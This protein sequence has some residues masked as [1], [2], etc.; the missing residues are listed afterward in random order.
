MKA[1]DTIEF[2]YDS[3]VLR[4][5]DFTVRDLPVFD[6]EL[7]LK[8]KFLLHHAS[9]DNN[10]IHYFDDND[11]YV[12]DK[13]VNG[14]F[15]GLYYH[16]NSQDAVRMV[17][18]RDYSIV[19]PYFTNLAEQLQQRAGTRVLDYQ[20]LVI[21][22]VVRKS[23]YLRPLVFEAN[24]IQ[25][26]YKLPD[27][28]VKAMLIGTNAV[29]PEWNAVNLEK[30]AYTAAMRALP[31]EFTQDLVRDV[32]GYNAVAKMLADTPRP[33]RIESGQRVVDLN[34]GLSYKSTAYEYDSNGRLLGFRVHN[35]GTVYAASNP[36]CAMVEM[37]SGVGDY[38]PDVRFGTDGIPLP[39]SDGYRVYRC[40]I[41]GELPDEDWEDITGNGEYT[42]NAEGNLTWDSPDY[43]SF[44]MVRTDAKFLAYDINIMPIAGVLHFTF[45][46]YEDRG[47]G[48]ENRV[49]PVPMGE[50]DLFL[51]GKSLIEGI[52]YIVKFPEVVIFNKRHLV[53]PANE[54]LQNIHVRFSGF[55]KS[56]LTRE[57]PGERGWVKY[58][59]LSKN[60]RYD[61]R[62]DKVLRIVM[63][64]ATYNRS[65]LVFSET[66]SGLGIINAQNG[67]PY[68]IRDIVVPMRGNVNAETYA[69]RAAAQVIDSHISNYLT[70]QLPEAAQ[71]GPSAISDRYPL[72]SPFIAKIIFDLTNG[73]ILPE[74]IPS[75][76]SDNAILTVCQPYERWLD[77]DPINSENNLDG[78]YVEIHP[79]NTNTV[80]PLTIV[81]YIFLRRVVKLYCDGLVDLSAFVTTV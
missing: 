38:A 39:T 27:T 12:L 61:I 17:T 21:Q 66:H 20:D 14:R 5:V 13:Q 73:I 35:T 42:I 76:L 9:Q 23:G 64:G 40:H 34:H 45:S 29:V 62:D 47:F 67:N 6:S 18:H 55:C 31:T 49:M 30:S 51:N 44:L 80:I 75:S 22:L 32:F 3:S 10:T 50:L 78:D 71:E 36:S 72:I 56:D 2:V 33:I 68:Q 4:T 52:D 59:M 63:G 41:D 57:L 19:V 74:N 25:E 46:E 79:W 24:R 70:T 15:A 81:Q 48:L 60:N 16:K 77:F 54:T 37:I 11:V 43:N 69:Y 58:G 7:D 1:G 65:D 28:T 26:L 8:R 53:E